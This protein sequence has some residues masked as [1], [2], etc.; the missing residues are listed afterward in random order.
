MRCTLYYPLQS[1][2]FVGLFLQ[3][4]SLSNW[5]STIET[6]YNS[7]LDSPC[8]TLPRLT[9]QQKSLCLE[10][11]NALPFIVSAIEMSLEECQ[12]MFKSDRW[13]CSSASFVRLPNQATKESAFIYSLTSA[14]VVH[15][16]SRACSSGDLTTCSCAK[17]DR[18]RRRAEGDTW[19]WGGCNDNLNYGLK[20]SQKFSDAPEEELHESLLDASSLANLHNNKVGR[21]TIEELT[22]AN[23]RCRCHGPSGSCTQKTCWRSIASLTDVATKLK[24]LYEQSAIEVVKRKRKKLRAV[25]EPLN[26]N[27]GPLSQSLVYTIRSPD[28]CVAHPSLGIKGVQDRLCNKTGTGLDS[29][30]SLCCGRGYNTQLLMVEENCHCEFHWC[31]HVTCEKC[32]MLKEI[33]TCK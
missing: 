15:S 17:V 16:I 33:Y 1:A 24:E 30:T 22:L 32:S 13:N 5:F 25:S 19:R 3:T 26:R 10:D 2:L 14:A 18:R 27:S 7:S 23:T 21:K 12:E 29:C 8:D 20:F 31:C 9:A 11:P 6:G 28:Y 4:H